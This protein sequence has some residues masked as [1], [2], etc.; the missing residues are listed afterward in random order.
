MSS[1]A[2]F[3]HDLRAPLAR[4]ITY[5]KLLREEPTRESNDLITELLRALDDLDQRLRDAEGKLQA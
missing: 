3:L 5:A 2:L 4:A 1:D